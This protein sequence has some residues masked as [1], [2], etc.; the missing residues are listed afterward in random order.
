[1]RR[2]SWRNYMGDMVKMSKDYAETGA[3][4]DE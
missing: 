1:M 3:E 2:R 4:H